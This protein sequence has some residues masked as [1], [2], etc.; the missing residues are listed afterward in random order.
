F[1]RR[2]ENAARLTYRLKDVPGIRPQ[3]LYEGTES[4]SFYLYPMS[5]LKEEFGDIDR[6]TFL[7][8][9]RAEGVNLSP[10]IKNGLH[11]EPWIEHILGRPVYRKMFSK[12]RLREYREQCECPECDKVC[13]EM[14]MIWASGP[15]LAT[16]DD[17]DDIADAIIK[18]YENRDKLRSI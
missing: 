14:A 18:V 13:R 17:M 7:K 5:Y 9:L 1:A 11:K 12:R 16:K 8:A 3:K 2:N 4:G 15:L 6:D 10:Y